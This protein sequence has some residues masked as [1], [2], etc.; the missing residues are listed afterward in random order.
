MRAPGVLD[1]APARAHLGALMRRLLTFLNE[2]DAKAWRTIWVSL[3]L[4]A[5]VGVMIVVG[6]SGLVDIDTEIRMLASLREG[7]WALPAVI[8]LFCLTAYFAAPQFVLIG[9]CVVAFGPVAGFFYS[10]IGTIVSGALTFWTGRIAGASF[11]QRYA[12]ET[13]KRLSRFIGRNDFLAS[14][15][16]RNVPTAPFI[17]VNMAFGASHAKFG[18]YLAGLALGTI[19]KTLI[20]ALLGQSVLSAMGGGLMLAIGVVIAVVGIWITVALAARRAVRADL[21]A[22]E[23]EAEGVVGVQSG[24]AN[25]QSSD[26][27]PRT[28]E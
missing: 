14:L 6:K 21:P 15:I 20:V 18:R 26:V 7:P 8:A 22:S 28:G 17:V 25:S 16:V 27:L 5:V 1:A 2:L 9:A 3:A 11:V 24:R 12:G 4:L 23:M 19:P 13:V 10:W